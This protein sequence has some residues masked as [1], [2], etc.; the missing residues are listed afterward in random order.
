MPR[1]ALIL[2]LLLCLPGCTIEAPVASTA[3]PAANI[4]P[5]KRVAYPISYSIAPEIESLSRDARGGVCT[6]PI[7]IGPA[8][9]QSLETVNASAFPAGAERIAPNAPLPGR[10][11]HVI[12][13]LDSFS[14]DVVLEP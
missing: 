8:L 1:H 2:S 5:A 6:Y 7:T 12:F 4:V 9:V 13:R 14:P 11:R 3:A 10:N